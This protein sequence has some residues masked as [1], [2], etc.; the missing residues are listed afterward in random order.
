[1][2]TVATACACASWSLLVHMH[3]D[4]IGRAAVLM[5]LVGNVATS[6]LVALLGVPVAYDRGVVSTSN[7]IVHASIAGLA[8]WTMRAR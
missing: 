5:L 2:L 4:D 3:R 8:L 7:D 6:L 1:M